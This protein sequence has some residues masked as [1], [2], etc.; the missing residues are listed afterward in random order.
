MKISLLFASYNGE[1]TLP[2]M[3]DAMTRVM[4]PMG[5]L[6]IIAVDNAST[7]QT[8]EV[9]AA[10]SDRLD[11]KII[12]AP[13][14]GKNRAL[15]RGLAH[16]TGE[17][18][19]LTDDDIIPNTDWLLQMERCLIA[20]PEFAIIG[21]RIKPNWPSDLP[22]YVK[23][24]VPLSMVFAI[25]EEQQ[26]D[27]PSDPQKIWGANMAVRSE[28]FDKGFRFDE[29]VGPA[30]GNYIMGSETE[31]TARLAYEG[32]SCYF[33]NASVVEHIIR[34][35]QFS[36]SWL[37]GRSLRSGKSYCR[38]NIV[39]HR[40][41][42]RV[43]FGVPVWIVRRCITCYLKYIYYSFLDKEDLAFAERFSASRWHGYILQALQDKLGRTDD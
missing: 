4:V 7:D 21:G 11:I 22:E 27:G 34:S 3:L 19:V 13:E 9:M 5:G 36:K 16:I 28:V 2:R 26:P 29:T 40:Q 17:V 24:Y 38:N 10:Y 42:F 1:K 15:N 37:W 23:R 39:D 35:N 6:E 31:F 33:C 14:R 43:F 18:V 30:S 8:A 20:N 41:Q 25:T 12:S 32:Y